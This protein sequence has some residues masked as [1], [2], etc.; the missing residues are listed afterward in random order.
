MKANFES[1]EAWKTETYHYTVEFEV[2]SGDFRSVDTATV[3]FYWDRLMEKLTVDEVTLNGLDITNR[4]F[5][6]TL[7]ERLEDALVSEALHYAEVYGDDRV[8]EN[9]K[10]LEASLKGTFEGARTGV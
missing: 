5:R 6:E 7:L 2:L 3:T 8:E 10:S 9:I 4:L 1:F